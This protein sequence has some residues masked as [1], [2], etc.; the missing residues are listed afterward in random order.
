M[1]ADSHS[2]PVPDGALKLLGHML[3]R[4]SPAF[5]MLERDDRFDAAEEILEDLARIRTVVEHSRSEEN[6]AVASV[7]ST[8]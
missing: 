4:Q 5:I 3:L 1:L 2:H 6:H 7:G 8:V